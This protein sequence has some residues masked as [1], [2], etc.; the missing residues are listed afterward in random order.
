MYYLLDSE[1]L[2]EPQ[3]SQQYFFFDLCVLKDNIC[4]ICEDSKAHYK[5]RKCAVNE[6]ASVRIDSVGLN[7]RTNAH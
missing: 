6:N 7:R 5:E 4:L 3:N 1:I 2:Y